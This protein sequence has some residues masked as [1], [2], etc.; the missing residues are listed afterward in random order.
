MSATTTTWAIPYPESPDRFCDGYLFTQRMA[1]RVD[2]I[3]AVFDTDLLRVQVIPLARV[4]VAIQEL[5]VFNGVLQQPIRY[6]SVDFDT[7]GLANLS[8][9]LS[10]LLTVD[11]T[12]VV[13]GAY[14]NYQNN[15]GVAGDRYQALLRFSTGSN[16]LDDPTQ[17]Q[18][19]ASAITFSFASLD[20]INT[21]N[22]R[23]GAVAD[24][25]GTVTTVI[26]N[27]ARLWTMKIGEF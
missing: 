27:S 13:T 24:Q 1:E 14:L 4:S 21:G 22:D 19:G 7:A 18:N 25:S 17:R 26:L 6:I 9:D 23:V 5:L 15:G 2:E 10:T 3:M 16:M 11:R 12:R 8:L 20:Q